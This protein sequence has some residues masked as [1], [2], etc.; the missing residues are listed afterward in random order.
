[1]KADTIT[2][3]YVQDASI[4]ADIFNY[5]VYQGRQVIEPEQLKERDSTK[6]AL[7]YGADGAVVPVQKFRDVQ[8]LY[9]AMTDG[10]IEYVLYGV[11]N[12]TEIH[13]AMPV[14]NYLYDALT[15]P[16]RWRRLQGHIGRKRKVG[17]RQGNSV[18]CREKN[19]QAPVNF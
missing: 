2:K 10:K 19:S 4:F 3:A 18:E 13:Y 8:K 12:Q 17:K 16:G 6:I 7:P 15:M 5:Y 9:A 11:E 14:K 1:M